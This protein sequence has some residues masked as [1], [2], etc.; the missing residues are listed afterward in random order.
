MEA[1]LFE[2][3]PNPN[4]KI[5]FVMWTPF[6]Y[7]VYKNIA[8]HL[9]ESEFVVCNTWYKNMDASRPRYIPEAVSFLKKGGVRWRVLAE[10]NDI[11]IIEAFFDRYEVI[12]SV[13]LEP[14][15]DSLAFDDWL[16][17]K[18]SVLISYG[19]GKDL[20]TFAPSVAKFDFSLVEGPRTHAYHKLLTRSHIV[21]AAKFDDWFNDAVDPDEIRKIKRILDPAKKTVLYLPTHSKIS[22]LNKF[23]EAICGLGHKYN[24]AV[25]L[26]YHNRDVN[27]SA[28]KILDEQAQKGKVYIFEPT[29][30]VLPLF[31]EAD[32]ILSDSSSAIFEAVLVD[33]PLIILDIDNE[34]LIKANEDAEEFNGLWYSGA[35]TYEKSIEQVVK[36]RGQEVGTVE[37]GPDCLLQDIA[38]ALSRKDVYKKNRDKLRAELFSFNDGKC[39]ERAAKII[40]DLF[41]YP[42]PEAPLLGVATRSFFKMF[43]KNAKY[44]MQIKEGEIARLRGEVARSQKL[45]KIFLDIKKEKSLYRKIALI[46]KNFMNN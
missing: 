7:W 6:H 17:K 12:A 8:K 27:L 9:P 24:V 23:A 35:L 30:D 15:L 2:E 40:Y 10:R 19:V 41:R 5:A 1:R 4:A 28:V 42:K 36:F 37:K 29:Q 16:S 22:S 25:K 44:I 34:Q 45:A 32:I 46:T 11:K 14:P 13:W 38:E 31:S 33:K 18:K 21:G 26:H 20:M 43:S 39:G 3:N